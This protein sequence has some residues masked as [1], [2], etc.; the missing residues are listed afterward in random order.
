VPTF[1]SASSSSFKNTSQAFTIQYGSGAAQ[2]TLG[3][4]NVQMAGFSVANQV[5]GE[6]DFF[7][8][9]FAP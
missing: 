8:F 6:W 2:G 3:S 9:D 7:L 4:D 1:N 5:F